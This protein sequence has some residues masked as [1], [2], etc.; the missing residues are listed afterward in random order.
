MSRLHEE[1]IIPDSAGKAKNEPTLSQSMWMYIAV[2]QT[3]SPSSSQRRSTCAAFLSHDE[4]VPRL[5][6][7]FESEEARYFQR[8]GVFPMMHIVVV[9]RDAYERN[10]LCFPMGVLGLTASSRIAG[11]WRLFFATASNSGSRRDSSTLKSYS[12]P[13]LAFDCVSTDVFRAAIRT[14]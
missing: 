10:S 6:P 12:R 14:A 11:L 1:F 3:L 2:Q 4:G 7:D 9:R 13:N 8:T 5:Y